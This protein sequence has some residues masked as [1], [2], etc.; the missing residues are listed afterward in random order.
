MG[1]W[2]FQEED[3]LAPDLIWDC[4]LLQ[5]LMVAYLKCGNW[6]CILQ[7]SEL[8]GLFWAHSQ[9]GMLHYLLD[10]IIP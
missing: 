5:T 4:G 6:T 7:L 2:A 10:A 1:L 9:P 3:V 8:L